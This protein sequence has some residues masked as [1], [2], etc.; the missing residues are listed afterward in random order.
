MDKTNHVDDSHVIQDDIGCA[1][2]CQ[3]QFLALLASSGE[4]LKTTCRTLLDKNGGGGDDIHVPYS[5]GSQL[6]KI[7]GKEDA[8]HQCALNT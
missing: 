4:M 6:C 1:A 7:N 8:D 5:C 3:A 2:E